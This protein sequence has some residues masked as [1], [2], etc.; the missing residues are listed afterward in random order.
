MCERVKTTSSEDL[1]LAGILAILED[2][3]DFEEGD[4][5]LGWALTDC[6]LNEQGLLLVKE[7]Q[8]RNLADHVLRMLRESRPEAH[9]TLLGELIQAIEEEACL[10]QMRFRSRKGE[11]L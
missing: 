6:A 1:L 10:R 8:A 5:K 4:G 7:G 2:M 11:G 3:A 9:A